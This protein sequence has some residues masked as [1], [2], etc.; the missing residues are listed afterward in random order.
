MF[1][2]E[3]PVK[4]N[5]VPFRRLTR[6]KIQC[7]R[8]WESY[9]RAPKLAIT[10]LTIIGKCF[11]FFLTDNDCPPSTFVDDR[12]DRSRKTMIRCNVYTI[13]VSSH[14]FVHSCVIIDHLIKTIERLQKKALFEIEHGGPFCPACSVWVIHEPRMIIFPPSSRLQSLTER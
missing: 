14:T 3:E 2:T 10:R 6:T 13:Y 11:F 7:Y 12:Y 5:A 1:H 9:L 4:C 8:R